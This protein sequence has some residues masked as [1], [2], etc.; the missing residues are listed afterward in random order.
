MNTQEHPKAKHHSETQISEHER[1]AHQR[2][3]ETHISARARRKS[4][5]EREQIS[6][7]TQLQSS[8]RNS[9]HNPP[10]NQR[11]RKRNSHKQIRPAV[12]AVE[13]E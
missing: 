12:G 10:A 6:A 5:H 7:R 1:D 8:A 9:G 2:T 4:A 11:K 13:G 3:S